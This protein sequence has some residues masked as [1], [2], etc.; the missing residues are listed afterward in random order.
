MQAGGNVAVPGLIRGLEVAHKQYGKYVKRRFFFA[1]IRN[2]IFGTFFYVRIKL[3]VVQFFVKV[4][5]FFVRILFKKKNSG[6]LLNDVRMHDIYI[7]EPM[8]QD[9]TVPCFYLVAF[10]L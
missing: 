7:Q 10:M 5:N 9:A 1:D 3:S 2:A 4:W 6:N 8:S